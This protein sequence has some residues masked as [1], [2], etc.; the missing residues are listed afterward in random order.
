MFDMIYT[1]FNCNGKPIE[2]TYPDG[3]KLPI[4]LKKSTF[5]INIEN[6]KKLL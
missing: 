6:V 1:K 5:D 2:V 4:P 3:T